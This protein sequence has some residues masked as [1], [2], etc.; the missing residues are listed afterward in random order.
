MGAMEPII[1]P[2]IRSDLSALVRIYNHYI[3]NTPATF[4]TEPYSA[5][6]REDWWSGFRGNGPHRLFV[7]CWGDS[8]VGYASSSSFRPKTAYRSSVETTVYLDPDFTGRGI[9][10]LLYETLFDAL[11]GEALHRAYAGIALPNEASVALHRRLGFEHI[12]TFREAGYK[13]GNYWDVAWYE[14]A[15]G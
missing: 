13:F 8:V 12:G 5:K 6:E 7:A 4:D 10:R 14:K 2:A 9:G 11:V 3:V 15:L 1:R